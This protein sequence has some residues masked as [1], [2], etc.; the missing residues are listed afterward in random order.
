MCAWNYKI[1]VNL[2]YSCFIFHIFTMSR[3]KCAY[4]SS[5]MIRIAIIQQPDS[6]DS[7]DEQNCLRYL[8]GEFLGNWK[9]FIFKR[10]V[11]LKF[12]SFIPLFNCIQDTMYA[13]WVNFF[14]II[15]FFAIG[16]CNLVKYNNLE[17]WRFV[18]MFWAHINYSK[19]V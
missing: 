14:A 1:N 7:D 11:F 18:Q 16:I 17:L 15:I 8:F 13:D 10:F 3:E 6:S 12:L 5:V 2:S 19:L 9:S 4:N